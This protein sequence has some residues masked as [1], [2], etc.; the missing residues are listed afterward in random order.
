MFSLWLTLF[1]F[2]G[3]AKEKLTRWFA[4]SAP[5]FAAALT[6]VVVSSFEFRNWWTQNAFRAQHFIQIAVLFYGI[7]AI[8]LGLYALARELELLDTETYPR[9]S[10]KWMFVGTAILAAAMGVAR[11]CLDFGV[12]AYLG[13][14]LFVLTLVAVAIVF[15]YWFYKR[16]DGPA[17]TPWTMLTLGTVA[18]LLVYP[19]TGSELMYRWIGWIW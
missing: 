9:V 10:L 15:G 7:V 16:V 17:P 12:T 13:G 1:T 8:P 14:V 2:T 6:L 4:L 5:L 3:I 11:P 18:L 19:F